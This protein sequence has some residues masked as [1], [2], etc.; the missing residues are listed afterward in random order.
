MST[1]LAL[2]LSL[3]LPAFAQSED[4]RRR[5]EP[6]APVSRNDADSTQGTTSDLLIRTHDASGTIGVAL[7]LDIKLVRVRNVYIEAIKLLG[8]PRGVTISD[9]TNT[10]SS[11]SDNNDVDVSAWDLS[12]I[13]I[14]QG[15]ERESSFPLAVAA[16][17]TPESGGHIDVT[18]SRLTVNFIPESM[19]RD[20]AARGDAPGSSGRRSAQIGETAP[21]LQAFAV[22]A[23]SGAP[24]S[25]V[26]VP[27]P[28]PV[29]PREAITAPPAIAERK[30]GAGTEAT[31]VP[32]PAVPARPATVAD[33]LVER[34]RGLIRLGDISGAR[35][36]LERA[37][38]RDAPNATFLLAQTWDPAMLR[39]WKV[40]GLRSDQDLA[41]SLYAKAARQ[42]R[43]D[44]RRLA[45][46]GR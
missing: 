25:D 24:P 9:S 42:D 14:L 35:L 29:A 31:S 26:F 15:D 6:T 30:P 17:W 22:V 5:S 3:S 40:R 36:L 46:T 33:P 34:A 11:T 41:Q 7:P 21:P 16:I 45:A 27:E 23:D 37:Q 32:R 13:Q 4:G 2:T 44:E 1:A 8:L 38:A 18:S 39:T 20:M 43:A 19:S 28:A 10:F 12:K